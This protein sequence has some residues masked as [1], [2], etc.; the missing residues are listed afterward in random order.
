MKINLI[1]ITS[2]TLRGDCLGVSGNNRIKT[3]N[4]DDLAKEGVYFSSCFSQAAPCSPSRAC[5]ATGCYPHSNRVL[6][7]HVPHW[8][9]EKNWAN[10]LRTYGFDPA[11][12]GYHDYC[13]PPKKL[14]EGDPRRE[15]LDYENTLPGF[16]TV[17]YHENDSPEY[18]NYLRQKGYSENMWRGD[19]NQYNRPEIIPEGTWPY[20]YPAKFRKEDSECRFLIDRAIDYIRDF[21][22]KDK[23]TGWVMNLNIL[24]PHS[25]CIA[26]EPFHSMYSPDDMPEPVRNREEL[27][28]PHPYVALRRKMST[29]IMEHNS[30]FQANFY[31]MVSE[32][33]YNLGFLFDELK[34]SGQWENT[35]IIFCADHGGYN[36]DHYLMSNGLF[37]DSSSHVPLIIRDPSAKADS[38]RGRIVD[39]LVELVDIAPT[40]GDLLTGEIPIRYQGIS[41]T[42]YIHGFPAKPLKEA[43]YIEEDYRRYKPED[44][45]L[46]NHLM[47]VIRDKEYKYVHFCDPAM[48]NVLFDLKADPQELN[49]L[50]KNPD[51]QNISRVYME[52]LLNWRMR[53]ENH[54]MVDIYWEKY[55]DK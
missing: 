11:L 32:L 50:I 25:P 36:G 40:I 43:I 49:N 33:D 31:G 13:I 47:W 27:A 17:L 20:S 29:E 39:D 22:K 18:R 15:N 28:N 26:P 16:S 46:N 19:F 48:P 6:Y 8:D 24:K 34:A 30:Q 45:D 10:H 21:R 2:D 12:V 9:A 23:G 1:L 35:I 4:I 42:P 7:N 44:I 5:M 54:D 51:Y 37:Y 3:P 53:N 38:T 52:H 14:P 41:L 55:D